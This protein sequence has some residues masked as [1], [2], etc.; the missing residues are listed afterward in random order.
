MTST[1]TSNCTKKLDDSLAAWCNRS[2]DETSHVLLDARDERVREGGHVVDYAV[3]VAEAS[4]RV[5]IVVC[6]AYLLRV[7]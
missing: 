2:L 4:Q 6:W 5:V 7:P 1:Q 3:L